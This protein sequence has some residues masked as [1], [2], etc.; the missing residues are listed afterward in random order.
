MHPTRCIRISP[1]N[2]TDRDRLD[3]QIAH[4]GGH[5][6]FEPSTCNF[7]FAA[8]TGET[9]IAAVELSS[10]EA[11]EGTTKTTGHLDPQQ[12]AQT[13]GQQQLQRALT[14]AGAFAFGPSN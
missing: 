13:V 6:V 8:L 1:S 11:A 4:L 2:R 5:D 3:G 7:A 9:A 10:D 12:V 14:A